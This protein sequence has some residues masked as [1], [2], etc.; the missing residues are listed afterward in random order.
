MHY[1]MRPDRLGWTIFDVTTGKPVVWED[2]P[3]T[4]L[5]LDAAH[6]LLALLHRHSAAWRRKNRVVAAASQTMAIFNP[7]TGKRV[8]FDTGTGR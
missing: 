7:L 3:L 6:E 2:V 8:T 4:G 5:D 1:D